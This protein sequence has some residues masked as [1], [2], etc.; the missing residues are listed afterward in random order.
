MTD[1]SGKNNQ[2]PENGIKEQPPQ[3]TP[4]PQATG[5]S[6]GGKSRRKIWPWVVGIVV[7]GLCG[8]CALTGLIGGGLY[9]FNN[10]SDLF[11]QAQKA[12]PTKTQTKVKKTATHVATKTST[13]TSEKTVKPLDPTLTKTVTI[14]QGTPATPTLTL[15][16]SKTLPAE[17]VSIADCKSAGIQTGQRVSASGY[18]VIPAGTY[19]LSASSYSIW[20]RT[21]QRSGSKLTV[22]VHGGKK[23]NS[24]YFSGKTPK[25][26][27]QKGNILSWIKSGT[28]TIYTTSKKVTVYGTWVSEC[29]IKVDTIQ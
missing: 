11:G 20:L 3:S 27:N 22:V 19:N 18:L 15:I 8:L 13:T 1:V 14:T 12:S 5:E 25:I 21:G 29:K 28:T 9:Y 17:Q 4:Q 23:D 6:E 10:E 7:V 2:S 24:M 26:I 16:P